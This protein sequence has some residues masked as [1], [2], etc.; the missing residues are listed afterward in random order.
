MCIF[1]TTIQFYKGISLHINILVRFWFYLFYQKIL[2]HILH[3]F[4]TFNKYFEH[5]SGSNLFFY[6][7][8]NLSINKLSYTLIN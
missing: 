6:K 5:M 1:G 4:K 8:V 3:D 7:I 2:Y